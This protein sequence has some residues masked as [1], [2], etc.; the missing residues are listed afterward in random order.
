[1]AAFKI[2]KL[3]ALRIINLDQTVGFHD[4]N[5]DWKGLGTRYSVR[6]M[7]VSWCSQNEEPLFACTALTGFSL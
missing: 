5:L 2:L 7:F 6:T 4:T 3:E 1:M